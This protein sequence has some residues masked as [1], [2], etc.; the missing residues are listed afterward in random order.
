MAK[1]DI[2]TST[3]DYEDWLGRLIKVNPHD[4]FK[5]HDD[6]ANDLG[7][8]VRSTCYRWLQRFP[9]VCKKLVKLSPEL[10]A[11]I[12]L[13][14]RQFCT[15]RDSEGRLAWSI[16]DYDEVHLYYFVN[17]LVRLSMSAYI[18]ILNGHLAIDFH[19]ACRKIDRGYET[20][21]RE[22]GKPYIL[23][24]DNLELRTMAVAR[25]K[26]PTEYFN[27]LKALATRVEHDSIPRSAKQALKLLL[28][29]SNMKF[30]AFHRQGGEGSLGRERISA[31][32]LWLGAMIAR[33]VK[34]LVPATWYFAEGEASG[35]IFYMDMIDRAVKVKDPFQ[36]VIGDYV[37]RRLAPDCSPIGLESLP[38]D[39]DEGL[40]LYSMGFETGNH[41]WAT[42]DVIPD[43]LRC[44]KKLDDDWLE[45]AALAMYEDQLEDWKVWRKYWS[46]QRRK[47][48][49]AL[50]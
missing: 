30:E 11:I 14:V 1:M 20:C 19:R 15:Y 26:D 33:E 28:P 21:L 16:N 47:E 27:K 45:E 5:K 8:F 44:L 41:H 24:E 38:K 35:Q 43:V 49:L 39:P 31:F 22:G 23:Q 25:L 42:P 40:L 12:D 2:I 17:D 13:H 46:K 32:G 7:L 50:V 3:A 9:R 6:M 29:D 48:R 10:L 4:L 37:G 36:K 18:S 34:S